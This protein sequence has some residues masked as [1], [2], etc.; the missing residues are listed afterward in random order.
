MTV[1]YLLAALITLAGSSAFAQQFEVSTLRPTECTKPVIEIAQTR[2]TL[3]AIRLA[4]LFEL[5]FMAHKE[6]LVFPDWASTACYDITATLAPSPVPAQ[7]LAPAMIQNLL[8]E[9]LGLRYH[10]EE[11]LVK[12]TRLE[13]IPGA[14][15][16]P[17]N[18]PVPRK[19]PTFPNLSADMDTPSSWR[20]GGKARFFCRSCAVD[21]LVVFL[22]RIV[23]AP[24]TDSTGLKGNH[25]FDITF[26]D[27][28]P[29]LTLNL[30]DSDGVPLAP[31]MKEALAGAG[32]RLVP[33][34]ETMS[35]FVVDSVSKVP[36][37][38]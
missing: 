8:I 17:S 21:H 24:V 36:T 15:E 6:R 11:R 9:R 7:S 38:N 23:E 2:V 37:A 28:K 18:A 34:K 13:R 29:S 10:S 31:S 3:R 1:I 35:V 30:K 27:P 16:P 22:T 26:D 20:T 14:A 33:A 4:T 25:G 32:F 19:D 12:L 5:S